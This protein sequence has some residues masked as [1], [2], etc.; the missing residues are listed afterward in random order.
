MA[1]PVFVSK[2]RAK[3]PHELIKFYHKD[4]RHFAKL[5]GGIRISGNAVASRF[6][7][8]WGN[9]CAALADF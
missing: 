5:K 1:Y 2:I 9:G 6:L 7:V 4:G 8:E 3:F